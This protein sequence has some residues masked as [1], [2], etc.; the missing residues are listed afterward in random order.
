MNDTELDE[1]LDTWSAP[2]PPPSLREHV[3]AGFAVARRRPGRFARSLRKSLMAVATLGIVAFLLVVTQAIP[4]TVKLVSPVVRTPYTVDSEYVRYEGDGA[5]EV[6]MLSTSY[7]DQDGKE[8]MLTR[9]HPVN[10]LETSLWRT[11]D[12]TRDLLSPLSRRLNPPN[13]ARFVNTGCPSRSCVAVARYPL[14]PGTGNPNV[15]C[16]D[17]PAF[18]RETILSYATA[19]TQFSFFIA[20]RVGV[21]SLNPER[22]MTVWMA[23]DLGCFA[24][25]VAMEERQPD[26]TFRLVSGKQAVKVTWN[27]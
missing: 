2:A 3:R 27:P 12:A 6:D 25:K 10:P 7:N 26:R 18:A 9:S 23:P 13:T 8:I 24:L 22:K 14:P 19:A 16:I 4:Q 20:N 5:R 11:I 17:G 15:G 21:G 1:I